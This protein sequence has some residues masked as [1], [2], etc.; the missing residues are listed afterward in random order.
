MMCRARTTEYA[1]TAPGSPIAALELSPGVF[2][3][4]HRCW[5]A[6]PSARRSRTHCRARRRTRR[7]RARARPG[8]D[9]Q[10][11]AAGRGADAG[12]G[13]R[14]D[15]AGRT[16]QRAGAQ[17]R[18]RR[19]PAAVR[20]P[21]GEPRGRR[22]PRRRGVL[23]RRGGAQPRR[24]GRALLAGRRPG[25]LAL[26]VDDAHW[27]DRPRCAGW[28]TWSTAS[29]SCRSRWSWP[30]APARRTSSSRRSRLHPATVVLAP[31]PLSAARRVA[32]E[33][34]GG[35]DDEYCRG[36]R[37]HRGNPFYLHALLAEGGTP[38]TVVD[39]WR[40]GWAGCRNP[41]RG[42]PGPW[43]C[44]TARRA[45]RWRRASPASTCAATVEAA[46]ALASA[47]LVRDGAFVHPL[48]RS[49]VYRGS[50]RRP[51]RAP[52]PCRPAAGRAGAPRSTSPPSWPPAGRRRQW[53]VEC[54]AARGPRGPG[55]R[56]RRRGRRLP[57]PGPRG[58]HARRAASPSC[59]SSPPR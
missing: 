24:A 39:T 58:G 47:D 37:G 48:V 57:A 18:V 50:R 13:R 45:G 8:G 34:L 35:P 46:E 53:A 41:A 1:V 22:R 25:P 6:T 23:R 44:W 43:P 26:V 52:R 20:A 21:H 30:S 38:Q 15:R 32:A 28:P 29:R 10:D 36:G 59:A 55:A 3:R 56:R 14:P 54:A 11:R 27:L 49:A 51:G 4:P 19:R 31:A 17:L 33:A 7:L 40:C 42:S 16:R 12:G 9:R 2:P 5:S